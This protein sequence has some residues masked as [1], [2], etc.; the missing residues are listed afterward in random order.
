MPIIGDQILL[1][2]ILARCHTDL[3]LEQPCE[4]LRGLEAELVGHLIEGQF[5]V[6]HVLLREIDDLVLDIA[7]GGEARLLLD[8]VT[9]CPGSK[10]TTV[11][12]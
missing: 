11:P 9:T 4:M 3:L 12:S 2:S 5:L 7:L 8:E 6:Q 1:V 10:L